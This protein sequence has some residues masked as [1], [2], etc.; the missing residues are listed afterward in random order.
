MIVSRF[1]GEGRTANVC[2]HDREWVV[3]CYINEEFV[4]EFVVLNEQ[5]A[6]DKA[7]NW[8]YNESI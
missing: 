6:E 4:E 2:K 5:D 8:I 3:M 7:E 1:E